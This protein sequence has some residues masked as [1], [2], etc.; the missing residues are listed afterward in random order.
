M[1]RKIGWRQCVSELMQFV[2]PYKWKLIT[3]LLAI[4]LATGL[5]AV[6]PTIEGAVTTQLAADA[7]D[8]VAKVTGARVHFEIVFRILGILM[9]CYLLRAIAQ[10]ISAFFLTNAI[11][12][13]MHDLRNVWAATLRFSESAMLAIHLRISPS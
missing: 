9:T 13:T 3:G 12:Q 5:Y 4:V 1:S 8:I 6:N 2:R 11:Q 10:L 7:S